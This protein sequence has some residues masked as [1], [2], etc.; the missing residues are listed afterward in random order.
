VTT[1]MSTQLTVAPYS[2][3]HGPKRGIYCM[4]AMFYEDVLVSLTNLHYRSEYG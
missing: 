2:G 3:P 4:S 1:W